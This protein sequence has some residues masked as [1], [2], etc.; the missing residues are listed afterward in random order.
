MPQLIFQTGTK[1]MTKS[2][3]VCLCAC[4]MS[5]LAACSSTITTYK[6]YVGGRIVTADGGTRETIEGIEVWENGAP[7][8]PF[9]VVGI[10]DDDRASGKI[11]RR[12]RLSDIAKK[13]KEAGGDAVVIY[14]EDS[15]LARIISNSYSS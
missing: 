13:A 8:R 3:L 1:T 6:E 12:H 10:V 15:T 2:L 14:K 9:R 5:V 7:N 11:P 4:L